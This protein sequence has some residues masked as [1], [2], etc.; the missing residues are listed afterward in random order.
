M[1]PHAS[2]EA[3]GAVSSKETGEE[4]GVEENAGATA[5]M[6]WRS[7][8]LLHAEN[9]A[10]PGAIGRLAHAVRLRRYIDEARRGNRS[11]S[12]T[13]DRAHL[14]VSVRADQARSD[15]HRPPPKLVAHGRPPSRRAIPSTARRA[16][17]SHP[18]S[19]CDANVS[20]CAL[21][22]A[23]AGARPSLPSATS[24]RYRRPTRRPSTGQINHHRE[25]PSRGLVATTSTRWLTGRPSM[26]QLISIEPR[27]SLELS[28]A[29]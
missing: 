15:Q 2:A 6:P 13:A 21:R 18:L 1:H 8:P 25:P 11:N 29:S 12:A 24:G 27:P 20:R 28:P 16:D 19:Y 14:P 7:L 9:A 23:H 17:L 22:P 3:E 10:D 4:R 5:K 26:H